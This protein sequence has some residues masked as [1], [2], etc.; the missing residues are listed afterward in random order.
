MSQRAKLISTAT[1]IA[2][3]PFLFFR[4]RPMK[5]DAPAPHGSNSRFRPIKGCALRHPPIE[6]TSMPTIVRG[7]LPPVQLPLLE[8]PRIANQLDRAPESIAKSARQ[9]DISPDSEL[10]ERK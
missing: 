8:V 9:S 6:E 7:R 10:K 2:Q 3:L 4:E 5:A 1:A